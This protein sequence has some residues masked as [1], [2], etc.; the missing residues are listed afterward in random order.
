MPSVLWL[1]EALKSS[2]CSKIARANKK[3]THTQSFYTGVAQIDKQKN[4]V[5][6]RWLIKVARHSSVPLFKH[7]QASCASM[8]MRKM[9]FTDYVNTGLCHLNSGVSAKLVI[10]YEFQ[11]LH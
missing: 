7:T 8:C 11:S 9:N 6:N 3:H 2:S 1:G 4:S 5:S 10:G